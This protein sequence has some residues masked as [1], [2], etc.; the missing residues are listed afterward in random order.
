MTHQTWK[1]V[2]AIRPLFADPV[3]ALKGDRTN[4]AYSLLSV[5]NIFYTFAGTAEYSALHCER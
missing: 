1:F 3:I 5:S 2:K 4:E